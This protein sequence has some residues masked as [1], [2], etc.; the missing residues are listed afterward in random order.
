MR[1]STGMRWLGGTALVLGVAMLAGC[2]GDA[3]VELA[4]AESIQSV[5]AQ[6]EVALAE[7]RAEIEAADDG[8]ERAA[9]DAFVARVQRDAQDQ[10]SVEAHAD[11]FAQALQK[12]GRDR[13]TEWSR[14][15]AAM[16]NVALLREMAGGLQRLAIDSLTLK[17]ETQ[18]YILAL[19][20][21]AKAQGTEVVSQ[22]SKVKG[23]G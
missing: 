11:Q 6:I 10:Q 12:L 7:Y 5:A 20:E 23:Q 1:G 22:R 19:I 9:I 2:G 21:N 16:D 17:D 15:H 18:R 8:R 13:R 4:A 3:R 14:H